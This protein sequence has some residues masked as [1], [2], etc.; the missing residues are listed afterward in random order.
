[1]TPERAREVEAAALARIVDDLV[2]YF[3]GI[4]SR[5]T[6]ADVVEESHDLLMA[7]ATVSTFLLV[8]TERFARERL[9]AQAK[10][11]G[12]R[13]TGTPEVL[14]VCVRNAGRSQIAAALMAHRGGGRVHVRSAG[15]Q[16]DGEVHP[17]V[18]Q[19]LAEIGVALS[20]AFPKPLTDDVVRASDVIVMMGCGDACPIYPGKRYLDWDLPDPEG[21]PIEQVRIIR[22]QVD[23]RVERLLLEMFPDD[24]VH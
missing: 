10:V 6:V 13:S 7:R 20:E 12:L 16:P 17:V 5:E 2:Y 11:L 3:N 21:Q 15:S 14:F 19:A 9:S 4:F 8:L 23:V 22:D 18:T 1:M 24:P